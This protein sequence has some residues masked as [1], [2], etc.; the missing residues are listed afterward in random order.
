MAEIQ[1]SEESK[2]SEQKTPITNLQEQIDQQIMPQMTEI[3]AGGEFDIT[4]IKGDLPLS[5]IDI[6]TLPTSKPAQFYNRWL[7][8]TDGSSYSLWIFIKDAW[9]AV[10]LASDTIY[11]NGDSGST[12]TID[13][14]VSTKQKITT[15]AACTLTFTAPP[16]PMALILKIVH[17]NTANTYAYTWPGTVKW[18][19]TTTPS[20]T[21]T[22]NAVDIV[23]FFWDGT[24]Y[25]GV[26]NQNF[27]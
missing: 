17:N 24:N 10:S 11:D 12:K 9:K 18:V 21:N 13:W 2:S 26:L 4:L 20:T 8:K 23:S 25:Y 3:S 16:Y 1:Q 27:G 5:Q 19:N 15:T 22:A 6:G 7:K 14:R